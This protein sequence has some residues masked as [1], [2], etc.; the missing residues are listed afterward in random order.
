M[1]AMPAPRAATGRGKVLFV[2]PSA[3]VLSGLATWLDYTIPG[4]VALGWDA[5][6]GLVA[7]AHHHLP[8]RYLDAHPMNCVHFAH[9]GT[10]T[11]EGRFRALHRM[12]LDV[13]PD[14]VVSVNIPDVQ[15]AIK[16][17]RHAKQPSPRL[18]MSLHGIEADLF[19]DVKRYR[20]ALDGVICTNRLACM[21]SETLGE[22]GVER[23]F[24]APC[25]SE[26]AAQLDKPC[27]SDRLRIVFVGRVESS[28]KRALD[29]IL[30]VEEL[31][32]CSVPFKLDV[33]GDGPELPTLRNALAA[34]IELG[35]VTLHGYLPAGQLSQRIY[36]NA[37]VLLLTSIWETGPIVAWEA[38]ANGLVVVSS[39]YLGSGREGALVHGHTALLFGV[40]D[41]EQAVS[42]L[43]Q[44]SLDPHL[45]KEIGE[46]GREIAEARYSTSASVQSWDTA[47]RSVQALPI[48]GAGEIRQTSASGRLDN[49][50]GTRAA[51]TVRTLLRR[52][53]PAARDPGGEWPH[54]HSKTQNDDLFWS[55][56]RFL[57]SSISGDA[58]TFDLN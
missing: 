17:I 35:A 7:G 1:K 52:V 11:P 45:R 25:G 28:Q 37:D 5:R 20:E 16:R 22:V 2:S 57:D 6:I 40:G 15:L 8:H 32:R 43:R 33:V 26:V 21:L 29:L 12:F 36:P 23:V 54:S 39:R 42:H 24:Y 56:A 41:H 31:V 51:E 10:G 50:L 47:L 38:M 9:C 34:Q 53:E 18:V 30:I 13:S 4:L 48:Q 58:R 44:L 46:R 3:Y 49:W 14:L 55:R 27:H 19:A